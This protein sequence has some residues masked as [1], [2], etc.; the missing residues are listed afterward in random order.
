MFNLI[1]SYSFAIKGWHRAGHTGQSGQ[2][3]NNVTL[4]ITYA[5]TVY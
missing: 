2:G 3:C 5:L 1:I 4:I